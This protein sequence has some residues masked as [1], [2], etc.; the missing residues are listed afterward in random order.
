[1]IG[2]LVDKRNYGERNAMNA[3]Q[4]PLWVLPMIAIWLL[5]GIEGLSP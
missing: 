3:R 2:F 5:T 1:M 4:T